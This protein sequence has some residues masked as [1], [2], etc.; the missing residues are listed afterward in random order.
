MPTPRPSVATPYAVVVRYMPWG[1]RVEDT[2]CYYRK[3]LASALRECRGAAKTW[4]QLIG[5]QYP[6]IGWFV[7]DSR[8]G[9]QHHPTQITRGGIDNGE[10]HQ[11]PATLI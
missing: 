1:G 11:P 8:S 10:S 7:V 2:V 3:H 6:G 9:E 4:A 5:A